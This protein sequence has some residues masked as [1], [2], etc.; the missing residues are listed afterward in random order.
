MSILAVKDMPI[1][2][3]GSPITPWLIYT[4]NTLSEVTT[5]GYLNEVSNTYQFGE[6][7]YAIVYTTDFNNLYMQIVKSSDNVNVSLVNPYEK[8]SDG[9]SFSGTLVGGDFAVYDGTTGIIKDLG[10]SPTNA[11]KTKVVMANAAVVSNNVASFA[12]TAGTVKDAGFQL[13]GGTTSAYAGGG[14]S[15]AF[16]ATGLTSSWIVTA[17]ILASTNP[18]SIVKAVPGTNTL[19]VTFSADPGANTTVSWHAISAAV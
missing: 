8:S 11:A 3:V 15:N 4:N 7:D 17:T 6:S 18:V 10:Y 1:G 13:K 19:T 14:T 9:V 16:T 2:I 5:T 12:D